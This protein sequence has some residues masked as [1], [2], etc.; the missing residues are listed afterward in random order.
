MRVLADT[1]EG[2]VDISSRE[3]VKIRVVPCPHKTDLVLP[4]FDYFGPI[5]SSLS[6]DLSKSEQQTF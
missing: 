6:A 4:R 1:A 2:R 3:Y 5:L